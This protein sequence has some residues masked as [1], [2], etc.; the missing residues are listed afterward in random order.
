VYFFKDLVPTP[1]VPIA[2]LELN[3][4]AGVMVT[5]SHNPG[6]DNGFKVYGQNSAQITSPVATPLSQAIGANLEPWKEAADVEQWLQSSLVVDPTSQIVNHYCNTIKKYSHKPAKTDA[7]ITYTAMHGVGFETMKLATE[8]FELPQFVPVPA[9][10]EPD[11]LFPTV[12]LPNPEEGEGALRLSMDCADAAGSKLI[13]AHDPDAD[14]LAVAE[15]QQDGEWRL[16]NGNEIALLFADWSWTNRKELH[17]DTTDDKF[18]MLASTVSSKALK[19]M[20]AHEGFQFDET[21]TGFKWLGN[22]A[23]ECEVLGLVPLLA[24]E[25]EIGFMIGTCSLDKD[26]I[27]AAAVMAELANQHYSTDMLLSDR[28][29]MLYN[30]Y[31]YFGMEASYFMCDDPAKMGTIFDRLRP[32]QASDTYDTSCGGYAISAVRDLTTG[33]DSSQPGDQA[34]LPVDPSS[35]MITFTFENGAV[36]TLRGS[37]TEPKLK[38]YVEAKGATREE[39]QDTLSSVT[40][41]VID[42]FLQPDRNEL[43][44]KE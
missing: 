20:A 23:A 26:G 21:L 25:V 17:P 35:Q 28:L 8:A 3:A 7:V 22:R 14:R 27:R 15:K 11:P 2:L 5:A 38:F 39:M 34:I 36:C 30:K 44:W 42:Q 13:L 19:A 6:T 1:L 9:Q 43:Q 16:F 40:T 37:G 18:I 12:K 24:Y 41:A 10:V 31:G 4:A 33:F 32:Q 29:E